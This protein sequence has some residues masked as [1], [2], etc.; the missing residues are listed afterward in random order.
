MIKNFCVN[1]FKSLKNIHSININSCLFL[2]GPNSSGKSSFIQSILMVAQTFS[3]NVWNGRMV[4]NGT[5]IRLGEYE[6]ILSHSSKDKSI[7]VSF[8]LFT[9][10]SFSLIQGFIKYQSS[11]NLETLKRMKKKKV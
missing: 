9:D 6:D 5:L 10:Y 3:D 7:S 1:G 2:C 4:L 11:L 8:D